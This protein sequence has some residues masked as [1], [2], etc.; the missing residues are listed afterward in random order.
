MDDPPPIK[1][2]ESD[3][4]GNGCTRCV[5]DIYEEEY[6][7]WQKRF[8]RN[9][10]ASK[11]KNEQHAC[12]NFTI[13]NEGLCASSYFEMRIQKLEG[14]CVGSLFHEGFDVRSESSMGPRVLINI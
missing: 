2:K 8:E 9:K 14:W 10:Q 6:Q 1:P 7:I 13:G 12:D 5:F 11:I 4:C 3:C